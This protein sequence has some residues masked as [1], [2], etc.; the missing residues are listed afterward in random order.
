MPE[1][2]FMQNNEI[3]DN[4]ISYVP[5]IASVIAIL[6]VPAIYTRIVRKRQ[7]RE[8]MQTKPICTVSD[9]YVAMNDTPTVYFC[10]N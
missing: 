4:P 1:E 8:M 3:I 2:T 5:A 10:N 7:L 6:A 9:F